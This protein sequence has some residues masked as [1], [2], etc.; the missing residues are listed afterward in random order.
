[1]NT[2]SDIR[3]QQRLQNFSRA[4]KLLREIV[5]P[6]D[7]LTTLEPIVKEGTIQRFEYTFELA[8]NTLK[9][10]MEAD[11]LELERISPRYVFKS[12]F[13]AKYIDNIECW[14]K[15]T[16]DRNLMSHTYNFEVFDKVLVTL[17]TEYFQ[18]LDDL[19]ISLIEQQLEG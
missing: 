5:E 6:H 16:G 15:M 1:M 19:H 14:L 3:W 2:P 9:D 13:Q 17:K 11:G 4:F 7:D 12:A 18:L 8:W 10:K